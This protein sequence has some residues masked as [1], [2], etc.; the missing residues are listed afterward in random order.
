[1]SILVKLLLR[2]LVL[3]AITL[4]L[5][6]FN[7]QWAGLNTAAAIGIAVAAGIGTVICGFLAHEWGH[8]LGA[9]ARHGRVGLPGSIRT[10]FLF[11]FDPEHNSREQFLAMSSG[12]FIASALIGALLL[13]VLSFD[14]LADRIALGLTGLGVLATFILELPPA[15]LVYRS[16]PVA[17]AAAG[18]S[19]R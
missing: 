17:C 18:P 19:A 12:G 14:G 5:W 8:L 6:Q 2:V 15:W 13:A 11:Q 4:A 7:H 3:L 9:L 16:L 10:V 1:M